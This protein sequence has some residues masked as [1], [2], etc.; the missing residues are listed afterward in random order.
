MALTLSAATFAEGELST[1]ETW[2]SRVFGPINNAVAQIAG[3]AGWISPALSNSWV[4]YGSPYAG[5]SYRVENGIV[6]LRGM[7]KLGTTGTTVFTLPPGYR[8][9]G[10]DA[11]YEVPS[12]NA[13]ARVDILTTGVLQVFG[14]ASGGSNAYVSLS[15]ISFPADVSSAQVVIPMN[16]A[17]SL[18]INNAT[19]TPAPG[20][21]VIG[22][23]SGI[24]RKASGTYS[25]FTYIRVEDIDTGG[26]IS[27]GV[28]VYGSGQSLQTILNSAAAAGKVVTF[29]AATFNWSGF[30][31]SAST[32]GVLVSAGK[33]VGVSGSGFSTIFQQVANTTSTASYNAM[34]AGTSTNPLFA[35]MITGVSSFLMEN[36]RFEWSTQITSGHTIYWNGV[37]FSN[38]PSSH[39][40]NVWF[41][42]FGPGYASVNP[43]ETFIID[44]YHSSNIIVEQSTFDGRPGGTGSGVTGSNIGLNQISVNFTVKNTITQY[45]GYGAGLTTYEGQGL[46]Q[47]INTASIHNADDAFNAERGEPTKTGTGATTLLTVKM[48]SCQTYSNGGTAGGA[49]AGI[50]VA[51]TRII[52]DSDLANNPFEIHDHILS[53]GGAPNVGVV[54]VRIDPTYGSAANLQRMTSGNYYVNGVLNN[55]LMYNDK[56]DP[57]GHAG[58]YG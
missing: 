55:H 56:T 11:I 49:G 51:G 41:N 18:A 32:Y 44:V 1:A 9:S 53:N 22:A 47:Y 15:G 43:G 39:I 29:P 12:N 16:G 52:F 21:S 5:I 54:C 4:A 25:G 48:F 26:S 10:T 30:N 19:V 35:W 27:G 13:T 2:F 14:Y 42:G 57:A 46:Y 58:Y 17:G 45:T 50:C 38:S 34:V 20:S 3:D 8:P 24:A 40:F 31:Q 28:W 6:Y 23:Q 7:M 36:A 37:D 33:A